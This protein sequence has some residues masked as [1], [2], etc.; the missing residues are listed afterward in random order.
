VCEGKRKESR[1]NTR[2]PKGLRYTID[3]EVEIL[4]GT[5]TV[6]SMALAKDI[7]TEIIIKNH[8]A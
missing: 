2:E 3:L 4:A 7:S 5:F 6:L 1:R 8:Y